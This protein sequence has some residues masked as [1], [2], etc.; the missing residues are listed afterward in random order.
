MICAYIRSVEMI[1]LP[2]EVHN[3][4]GNVNRGL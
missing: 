3:D 1:N 2:I 4:S